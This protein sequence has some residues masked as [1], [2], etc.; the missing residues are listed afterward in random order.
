MAI[1]GG[2]NEEETKTDKPATKT[3]KSSNSKK[4]SSSKSMKN[5]YGGENKKKPG[6]EKKAKKANVQ[7]IAYRVLL[8]PLVTEK[9]TNASAENKY[10]FEVSL[11]AN[12]IETAKSIFEVYGIWP[13][14]VNLVKVKGK[15]KR[16]GR[17]A[18][19]RKDW[20]KAIVTLPKGES[21]QIYEGI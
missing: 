10:V 4:D 1:F 17:F 14:K 16:Y 15:Q 21:I 19:K 5:L 18:G 20:K 6:T 3:G 12:K 7:G 8:K 13:E 9:A 2:K 11:Q